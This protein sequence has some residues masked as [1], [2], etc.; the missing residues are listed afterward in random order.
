LNREELVEL[1]TRLVLEKLQQKTQ[2]SLDIPNQV[3]LGISNRHVHLSAN[4]LTALFGAGK[5]LTRWKDLSQPG[6]Y[7]CEEKVTLIGPKGVIEQ[8]RVLGPIRSR[9]QVEV[10]VTDCFK[11][12]IKP[13]VRDSGDLEGSPGIILAGPTG[14]VALEEGCIVAA[15]HVHMTP[16]DAE[17]YGLRD[18]DKISVRSSGVR[19]VVF[20]NVLVRVHENYRWELH[21]DF[22]EANGACLKCG[23]LLEIIRC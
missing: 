14:V 20:H 10:S 22:D 2:V 1:V 11:L 17:R 6:Q 19:S 4:D 23:D 8:V 5:E 3:P 12:G 21:L 16:Q 13:V 15:R 18:K 7:A 9:T